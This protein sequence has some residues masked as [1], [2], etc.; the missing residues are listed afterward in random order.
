M[1]KVIEIKEYVKEKGIELTWVD[2]FMIK[3]SIEREGVIISANKEGLL[4]L[5]N[6]LITLSQE[7][8]PTGNHL[9]FDELNSLEDGSKELIICK[10]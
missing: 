7:S 8:I 2:S 6:H 10:I 5:A 3:C 1:K 4:S 9:H